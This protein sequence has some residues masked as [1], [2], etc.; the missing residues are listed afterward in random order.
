[1]IAGVTGVAVVA[2]IVGIGVGLGSVRANHATDI[3]T[4]ATSLGSCAPGW[5]VSPKPVAQGIHSDLLVAAAGTSPEDVWAVGTRF[6]GAGAS[7]VRAEA[8]FEHWDGVAWSV[9]PGADPGGRGAM[10][11]GIV[12]LAPD[13][14]WA[15]GTVAGRKAADLIEHWDGVS[16][17]EVQAPSSTSGGIESIA[18]SA[19]D[20]IWVKGTDYPVVGGESIDEDVYEHWDGASWSSFVGPRAVD[21]SLGT[22]TTQVIAV[23]PTG[24]AWAG[25]GTV[26]GFGEA[27]QVSGALVERWDGTSWVQMPPPQGDRPVSALA[28]VGARDVWAVLG[29]QLRTFGGWG[30]GGGN[31]FV[32]WDGSGWDRSVA[33]DG[34]VM[35]IAARSPGDVWA[36]GITSQG[37]PLVEHWNGKGW[38]AVDTNAPHSI[39]DGLVAAGVTPTGSLIAS[40]SGHPAGLGGSSTGAVGPLSSY[41]WIDCR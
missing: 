14:A 38:D 26:K 8:L 36:V 23:G 24:E 9:V 30:G 32:H 7:P 22:S 39:T 37:G 25:G 19:P 27:G 35:Q 10:L 34:S 28:V 15:V 41:L 29:G 12:A 16:W 4:P 2:S 13:D 17:S 33:V 18:A 20:D 1:M 3:Q 21:A 6:R 31:V 11:T 40:G 5:V